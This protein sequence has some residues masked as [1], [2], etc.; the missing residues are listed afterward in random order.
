MA[1]AIVVALATL[2]SCAM[3]SLE[4]SQPALIMP[5]TVS[6]NGDLV[7]PEGRP[8]KGW[9]DHA[10][11][12]EDDFVQFWVRDSWYVEKLAL[13]PFFLVYDKERNAWEQ[14]EVW[15]GNQFGY[16][17]KQHSA[18]RRYSDGRDDVPVTF[19]HHQTGCVRSWSPITYIDESPSECLACEWT[20]DDARRLMEVLRRPETYPNHHCYLIW[21]GPNSNSYARWV[22]DQA[23]LASDFHPKMVG[24]DWHGPIGFGLT[25]S[26]TGVHVDIL[27]MGAAVGL[28]DGLELHV[29]GLTF[30]IDIW[31]PAIKTPFG[32]LGM[33]E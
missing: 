20:G 21:P 32:R 9:I 11:S 14:W 19:T 15:G 8:S 4:H 5:R 33:P 3:P 23:G 6:L 29:L 26:R 27:T 30:G 31:P 28:E 24:K 12:P 16:Y 17:K 10:N 1:L 7:A 18:K 2:Q 13:H 25:P 22:L